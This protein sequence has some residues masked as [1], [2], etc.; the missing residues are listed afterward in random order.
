MA[1]YFILIVL[2]FFIYYC[3]F[4]F[5]SDGAIDQK[6]VYSTIQGFEIY[7]RDKVISTPFL[8]NS[9]D[10]SLVA[11]DSGNEKFPYV[12]IALNRENPDDPDGV[13]KV[14]RDHPKKT[15]CIKLNKII[16]LKNISNN[17][18]AYLSR[19]CIVQLPLPNT[20]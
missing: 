10:L 6:T 20:Q 5:R 16:S 17:P 9:D 3:L 19:F 11:L 14:G 13:Y 15:D 2:G 7:Y 12:W 18:K 4:L 8:I 1:R